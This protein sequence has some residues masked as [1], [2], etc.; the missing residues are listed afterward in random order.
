MKKLKEL[1]EPPLKTVPESELKPIR[2][3]VISTLC[4]EGFLIS[5]DRKLL[6]G[7][8]STYYLLN[9]IDDEMLFDSTERM[10]NGLNEIV[11]NHLTGLVVTGEFADANTT[12]SSTFE[13]AAHFL[14]FLTTKYMQ[15][16]EIN[17]E[18]YG[19]SYT[20]LVRMLAEVALHSSAS[21]PTHPELEELLKGIFEEF[22]AKHMYDELVQY[23]HQSLLRMIEAAGQLCLY[24]TPNDDEPESDYQ[25]G[26]KDRLKKTIF[27]VFTPPLQGHYNS[28][29]GD[30]KTNF[31]T[32][33]VSQQLFRLRALL[34]GILLGFLPGLSLG[35]GRSE[36]IT[37]DAIIFFAVLQ[38]F[39][40][41]GVCVQT[42]ITAYIQAPVLLSKKQER[43]PTLVH[44]LIHDLSVKKDELP[45]GQVVARCG[46]V[47]YSLAETG[48]NTEVDLTYNFLH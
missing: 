45:S 36:A 29:T 12:Y 48:E 9:S 7:L 17:V 25:S 33:P 22:N 11:T 13:E 43:T 34:S 10:T 41:V 31:D 4:N 24:C 32:Y 27:R 26:W 18:E 44:E 40:S 38:L 39:A 37:L 23:E 5:Q 28:A 35:L 16:N 47:K 21:K 6:P 3:M 8:S 30:I 2:D 42:I 19:A 46:L 1:I 20:Q 15:L 14:D